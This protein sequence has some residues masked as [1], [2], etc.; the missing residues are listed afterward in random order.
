MILKT[1][2]QQYFI[3]SGY[4]TKP[5]NTGNYSFAGRNPGTCR[6][7]GT[8]IDPFT[9]DFTQFKYTVVQHR[10]VMCNSYLYPIPTRKKGLPM[11]YILMNIDTGELFHCNDREW[12]EAF[13]A[14]KAD[15]WRPDG[16]LYDADFVIDEELDYIDDENQRLFTIVAAMRETFIWEGSYTDRCNQIVTYEDS[17]YLAMSLKSAGITGG[18]LEFVQKGSFR[19]CSN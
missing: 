16:T 9:L 15:G 2:V 18:L 19:I 4:V 10:T 13:E 14:A 17:I 3:F 8:W 5:C 12:I 11:A 6:T 1:V 7:A